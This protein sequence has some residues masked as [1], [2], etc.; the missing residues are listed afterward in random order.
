MNSYFDID[1]VLAMYY[2]YDYQLLEVI[3]VVSLLKFLF[4]KRGRVYFW[5]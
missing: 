3:Q 5:D 2:L 4:E 1:L